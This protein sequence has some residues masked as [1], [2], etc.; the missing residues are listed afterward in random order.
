MTIEKVA[1]RN[2]FPAGADAMCGEAALTGMRLSSTHLTAADFLVALEERPDDVALTLELAEW[3]EADAGHRSAWEAVEAS[4]DVLSGLAGTAAAHP[5]IA[6]RRTRGRAAHAGRP[7]SR[8]PAVI[9]LVAGMAAALVL[10]VGPVIR[11]EAGADYVTGRG[12]VKVV[13][14]ADGSQVRLGPQSAMNVRFNGSS[15]GVELQSGEAYFEV[16]PDPGRPFSVEAGEADVMVLGTGFDVRRRKNTTEVGVRH[17]RVRV[18]AG[19]RAA[20]LTAG[21]WLVEE[22]GRFM[23]G[24]AAPENVGAWSARR[25][26]AADRPVGDVLDDLRA[27]TPVFVLLLDPA[28]ARERV[29][30]SYD[31]VEPVA[32]IKAVVAPDGGRVRGAA[33]W[34]VIIDRE[35]SEK[36]R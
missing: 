12:E 17:G 21:K 28:L 18:R 6:P 36:N 11:R 14:L 22:N 3:L 13:D 25:V 5:E 7:P 30:G 9:G 19:I 32:A 23:L 20:E 27:R 26:I 2:V 24:A 10:T 8:R 33:P 15:R 34:L 1:G 35:K 4:A 31:A 29:T 16:A